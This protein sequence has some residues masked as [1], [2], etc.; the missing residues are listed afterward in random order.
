MPLMGLGGAIMKAVAYAIQCDAAGDVAVEVDKHVTKALQGSYMMLG[1]QSGALC[2]SA[3]GDSCLRSYGRV[4]SQ[5]SLGRH[6]WHGHGGFSI[7][8]P[9]P[10]LGIPQALSEMKEALR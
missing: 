8:L 5:S 10:A 7:F 4:Q 2:T 6:D 9:S 1:G 3:T